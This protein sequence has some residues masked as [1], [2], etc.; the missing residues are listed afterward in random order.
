M[1]IEKFDRYI[2]MMTVPMVRLMAVIIATTAAAIAPTSLS[3]LCT[4][5]SVVNGLS[6]FITYLITSQV[7]S[8][9][10]GRMHTTSRLGTRDQA[11]PMPGGTRATSV[12][13]S[14]AATGKIFPFG[15]GQMHV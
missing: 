9:Q 8:I 12:L 1:G 6:F 2:W 7:A 11:G 3:H 14:S 13:I 5:S 4:I 15:T 10:D